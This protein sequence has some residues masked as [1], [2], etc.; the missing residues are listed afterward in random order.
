M[1]LRAALVERW[2]RDSLCAFGFELHPLQVGW[3][4]TVLQPSFHLAYPDNTLAF[5]VLSTPSMFDKAF[6][7]FVNKQLLKR[8]RDPVDQCISH[9]LSLV[10]E[11]FPDEKVHIIYDYEMLPNRKPKFLAQTAAHVS[12]AAYY[13]QRK[14]VKCDPW[15]DKKIYGV[16]IHP[17][18][19]GWFAIRAILIFPEI[20]VPFLEQYAPIDC[21]TTEEKRI[22]LLEK[23]NFH[24]QDWSYRD[25]IEVKE[26][27]SE[28]QK[29]YFATPPAERFKLLGLQGGIQRNAFY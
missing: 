19:G 20:Q 25:I 11:H 23:F 16:C 9:H 3:Y 10:K 24:W 29:T 2:L 15:G 18:Y 4:N 14:D 1:E 22:Q 6:K 17:Q 7:P 26:R 8:I 28:E 13:Y 12:G 5:V 21:V 27:Y